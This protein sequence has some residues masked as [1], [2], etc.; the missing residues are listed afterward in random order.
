MVV[1]ASFVA[2]DLDLDLLPYWVRHYDS[3][4]FDKYHVVLHIRNPEETR[5]CH[6]Q[7][8]IL[9][10][11]CVSAAK[12]MMLSR[13]WTVDVT[14][15]DFENSVLQRKCLDGIK[16]GLSPEDTLVVAD[17]D[18][19]QDMPANYKEIA[20]KHPAVTGT[21]IDRWDY[22]LHDAAP[23]DEHSLARLLEEYPQSGNLYETVMSKFNLSIGQSRC[24][25][26]ILC[27]KA[28]Y[29]VPLDGAHFVGGVEDDNAI[30][31]NRVVHHF[32]WRAGVVERFANRI[33]VG[34]AWLLAIAEYF[35][36]PHYDRCFL[37]IMDRMRD[38]LLS[39][40]AITL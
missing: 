20:E 32:T 3:F 22:R 5:L 39:G 11:D 7:S 37:K 33:H 14:T 34:P 25:T 10:E 13:G 36:V 40:K 35:Q 15:G 17:S 26:K 21:L 8:S 6:F 9:I 23:S 19:F 38:N 16:A 4:K 29:R 24:R 12:N 2:P 31:K 30:L 18:E 28:R 1:F 27:H